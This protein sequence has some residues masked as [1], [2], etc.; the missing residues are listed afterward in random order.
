MTFPVL[1][2]FTHRGYP[3]TGY[4]V[5]DTGIAI[6][7]HSMRQGTDFQ[8][9]PAMLGEDSGRSVFSPGRNISLH[10]QPEMEGSGGEQCRV[11]VPDRH[12]S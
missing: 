8:T 5:Q 2:E 7:T 6:Q 4:K 11:T 10:F 9:V 1:G 3:V 12:H